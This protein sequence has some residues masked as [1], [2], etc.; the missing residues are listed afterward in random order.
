M[1]N[2]R[3]PL[4]TDPGAQVFH[5]VGRDYRPS[6]ARLNG[7]DGFYW[8]APISVARRHGVVVLVSPVKLED[9]GHFA[10]ETWENYCIHGDLTIFNNI[11]MD[12]WLKEYN[13]GLF[14]SWWDC[15]LVL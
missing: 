10:S 2:H 13:M 12:F 5:L 9:N 6:M 1:E 3:K 15:G 4:T 7:L 8:A 11:I 14:L